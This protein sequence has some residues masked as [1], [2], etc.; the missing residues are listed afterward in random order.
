MYTYVNAIVE[1]P[2]RTVAELDVSQLTFRTIKTQY[3]EVYFNLYN[4]VTYTAKYCCM[5][6]DI[7]HIVDDTK[8]VTEWLNSIGNMALPVSNGFAV[9]KQQQV[10]FGDAT[11]A[12]YL[13]TVADMGTD[14]DAGT[15]IEERDDLL[16]SHPDW[17]I[18]GMAQQTMITVNG[19]FHI[20]SES[21][22]GCYLKN[23][24][25]TVN[26]TMDT[27][28]GIL[29][30]SEVGYLTYYPILPTMVHRGQPNKPLYTTAYITLEESLTDKI[31]LFSICGFLLLPGQHFTLVNGHT[32]AIDMENLALI[33]KFF[34][35]QEILQLPEFQGQVLDKDHIPKVIFKSDAFMTYLLTLPQSFI[36]VLETNNLRYEANNTEQIG[37]PGRYKCE[38]EPYGLLRMD[39][40]L[41]VTYKAT[42]ELGEWTL[43]C[44]PRA[45]QRYFELNPESLV[46]MRRGFGDSF[47]KVAKAESLSIYNETVIIKG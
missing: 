13:F 25:R 22:Y 28:V 24:G 17:E 31:I 6:S 45:S 15:A 21:Q 43:C 33:D 16:L 35:A 29:D 46:F 36:V 44:K 26:K 10:R 34:T 40:G 47:G 4:T 3:R 30:F 1:Y 5:L 20:P 19:L 39:N 41:S 18:G 27:D 12:G 2:D 38:T 8:M 42:L 14:P 32:I 37:L 9:I 11:N 23:G 7:Y